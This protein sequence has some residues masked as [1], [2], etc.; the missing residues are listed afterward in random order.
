MINIAWDIQ[1]GSN[2]QEYVC[3]LLWRQI[4]DGLEKKSD[5]DG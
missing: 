2:R 3:K 1:T 5:Y 4:V